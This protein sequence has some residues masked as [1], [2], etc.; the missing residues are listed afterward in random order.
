MKQLTLNP[1]TREFEMLTVEEWKKLKVGLQKDAQV[2]DGL[3]AI[4]GGSADSVRWCFKHRN[5]NEWDSPIENV[6]FIRRFDEF[7]PRKPSSVSDLSGWA[8][9]M[10]DTY[11]LDKLLPLIRRLGSVS[12]NLMQSRI[13]KEKLTKKLSDIN[14][15]DFEASRSERASN[16]RTY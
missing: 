6:W 10:E 7:Y 1:Q 2:C 11:N 12:V 4:L 14:N 3:I 13:E 8:R 16:K 9:F 5:I 15:R